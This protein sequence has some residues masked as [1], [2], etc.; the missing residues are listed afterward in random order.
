VAAITLN[1]RHG[2][3]PIIVALVVF[4]WLTLFL[5]ERSAYGRYLD[6]G[7]WTDIGFAATLCRA[8]PGGSVVLPTLL[9]LGG[10]VL[11]SAAMML[12]T[13]LPLLGMFGRLTERRPDRAMLLMLLML[14]Y[15]LIWGAFGLA[16]HMIDAVLHVLVIGSPWLTLNGWIIGAAVIA[17]AGA[18]Q[19]SALKYH[20]LEKCRTPFSFI[21]E[22]W[23]GRAAR[24]RAFLLGVH[25]GV[26][27]VGCC[28]AIM[29]L[30]FVVGTGSVGWML[31]LGAVMAIEKN[32]SWG[33]KLSAPLGISLLLW[34]STIIV[35]YVWRWPI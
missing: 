5:W 21:Q 17:L 22:H 20:C 31:M 16:A 26:F 24:L 9:Y 1:R 8:L 6:H 35:Q 15:L 29:L 13:T 25:H 2:F 33:R 27:C 34:S 10:W 4:A 14:G 12:P 11:M 18:F 3:L 28:W 19:F 30:M 32:A 23:R 7:Q